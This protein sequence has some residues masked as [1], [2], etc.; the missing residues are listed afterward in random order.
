MAAPVLMKT[1]RGEVADCRIDDGGKADPKVLRNAR[2]I[3][4]REERESGRQSAVI[5]SGN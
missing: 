1:F 2:L 3:A 4:W 5:E